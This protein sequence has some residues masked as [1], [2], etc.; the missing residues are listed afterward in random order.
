M[1]ASV[2][3]VSGDYYINSV[4]PN[5]NVIVNTHTVT[6]NGNLNVV[7][8]TTEI[9][10]AQTT[11]S[12]PYVTLGAGNPGAATLLG[13]EVVKDQTKPHES[14]EQ[15][16][17]LRWN[18]LADRWELSKD[19]LNW[20]PI[21]ASGQFRLYDDPD[22]TL[23]A[24]LNSNG[25]LITNDVGDLLLA[26][27]TNEV[28][29]DSVVKLPYGPEPVVTENFTKIHAAAPGSGGSGVYFSSQTADAVV[30]H[31]ELISRSKAIIY[32]IIF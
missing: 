29:I 8:N 24:R 22:P 10:V 9:Q 6:I 27:A 15:K 11:I 5:D 16:A 28:Q 7:G 21:M 3:R 13:I 18:T 12:D 20:L 32:S 17:G 2:K 26:A 23:S 31:D 1:M 14:G 4:K 25:Q 19:N 30:I